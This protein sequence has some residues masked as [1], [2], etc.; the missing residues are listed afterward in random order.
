VKVA[1]EGGCNGPRQR[2]G[3]V[4][5]VLTLVEGGSLEWI[6]CWQLLDCWIVVVVVVELLVLIVGWLLCWCCFPCCCG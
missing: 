1:V 6:G 4:C 3:R 5:V 2:E